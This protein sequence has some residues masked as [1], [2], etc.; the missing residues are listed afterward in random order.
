MQAALTQLR[1]RYFNYGR[2]RQRDLF[3]LIKNETP[4][5]RRSTPSRS[6]VER[7]DRSHID[8]QIVCCSVAGRVSVRKLNLDGDQ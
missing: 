2:N 4:I 8:S 7:T 3:A 6:A 1:Q 5:R